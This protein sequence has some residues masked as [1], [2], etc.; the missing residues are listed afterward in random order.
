MATQIQ[1]RRDTAANWTSTNPTM[2]QGEAGYE[3]DTGKLKIGDG[4]TAWNSL[5]YQAAANIV[6]GTIV[7]ADV[8][9]SAAI[10]GTKISPDFGS[11]NVV[12]TGTSTAASL[13]PTGSSVPTN[14]VYLPA[15]NSVGISTNG[16]GRLFVNASGNVGV[17]ITP[18]NNLHVSGGAL[19]RVLVSST[20]AG[21]RTDIA[22][23]NSASAVTAVIGFDGT[24]NEYDYRSGDLVFKYVGTEKARLTSTGRFEV[25]GAGTAGVSP[26]F[27]INGSAPANSAV[28]D[29]SGRLGLGTSSPDT[30]LHISSATGTASPTPTELRIATTSNAGDWSTSAP[31]GRISFYSGDTSGAGPKIHAAIDTISNNSGSTFSNLT[32]STNVNASNTLVER[33][34]IAGD[35]GNVGIGTTSPSEALH[36]A[37]AGRFAGPANSLDVAGAFIDYSSN[38]A[39]ITGCAPTAGGTIAFFTNPASNFQQERARIDSSGTFR[40]K[41]AGTVGV[42]DAF[43]VNGS[44]PANSAQIDSSGRLLVGTST[45][46][47]TNT[48]S[49]AQK[50]NVAGAA[51]EGIQLQGYSADQFNI[52]IDFSKSRGASVG[53]NTIVQNADSLGNLIFNGYD[54]SAYKQAAK[55]EAFV[56]GTPG[57]NDMPGRLVFSTTADGASSPTEGMRITQNGY[58]KHS[59]NG[60]Y[61]SNTAAYHEFNNNDTEPCIVVRSTNASFANNA[62]QTSATRA[63]NSAYRLFAGYSDGFADLEFGLYGDGNGKCDGAWTGGGADYAEYFEWTD[64]NPDADDRRGIAVVLDGDKIRPALAGEDPIGVISGNPSVVGDSAWNKWSGKYLRD[65]YGTYIQEDYEVED[66]DGNTVIQQRR[67]LNPAYDPD[68]E[69]TSREER[70]EWGCVGLMGKLRLRKGQPTGS[71][72]IKM[73]DISDS[74]EEWLVR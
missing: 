7:N 5:A 45:F 56:D 4:S 36:V 23:R 8:N 6:D 50:I 58:T 59:N 11:Q 34:R 40:V 22:F 15:A 53:T 54:G 28:V 25:K 74:V 13:I 39:R 61:L 9:A 66:E 62:L 49:T 70:P 71:R 17:G 31:W 16:S 35:S 1:L 27:S 14:G 65:E 32:F 46:A 29:S 38:V 30:L 60:V 48:Y 57:A 2:A 33:M 55:I 43:A 64:G 20:S 44:A 12:T 68:V 72:W 10:A 41:G 67:K 19:T 26:A 63:A 42:N 69:Y 73:R 24:N 37:N 3:T 51:G 47:Q 52:A 18:E 21:A